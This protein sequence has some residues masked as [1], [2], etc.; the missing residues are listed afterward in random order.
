MNKIILAVCLIAA[1]APVFSTTSPDIFD[2]IR[3]TW[4]TLTRSNRTLAIA[5]VDP[6]VPKMARWP[7]YVAPSENVQNVVESLRR[8]MPATDFAK[9]SVQPLPPHPS[10]IKEDG[11]LYLPNPYVVPGGRFNEMYGWDSYFIQR[12]LL[13]DGQIELAKDMADNF[14]YE[15]REYGKVLNANRTYYLTRSQP[16]FLTQMVLGVYERT[17]DRVWLESS[18]PAIKTYYRYWTSE[19]HLTPQTGLSRYFDLGDSPA[20]EVTT[21]ERDKS[22]RTPY[23]EARDYYRTHTVSDYDAGYYYDAAADRLTDLF[24]KGDRSMRESGFDPSNRWGPFGVDVIRYN[25]VCLNSLLYLMEEQIAQMLEI[26]DRKGEAVPWRQRATER[27]ERINRL[28]WDSHDGLYYD[29]NFEQG[30]LRRYAFLTTFYPLWAGIA[31]REQAA[32]VVRNLPTFEKAGGLAT[33]AIVSGDQWD[34]PFGWAPL[35]L[36]AVEALR[37]YG[38]HEDAER[39][40]RNFLLLVLQEFRKHRTVAEKYDVARRVSN[41]RGEILFGYRTNEVGFGWTNAVFMILADQLSP[42]DQRKLH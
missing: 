24:Y 17:H 41:L 19:P 33:S 22:G 25:P 39:V 38:Y 32:R 20:P 29:Y 13:Q 6:K 40:S 12:G 5:A 21:G 30:R 1:A 23:D 3:Q 11:L 15:V 18:I 4:K 26:A 9:V 35:Q 2:F 14:L 7:V 34:A 42:A 31:S 8:E 16:P 27:S 28:L 36:I 10:Q 37:R